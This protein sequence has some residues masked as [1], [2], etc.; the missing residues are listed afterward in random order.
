M[1]QYIVGG[2]ISFLAGFAIPQMSRFLMKFYP[3]SMHSYV[4]DLIRFSCQNRRKKHNVKIDNVVRNWLKKQLF[5]NKLGCGFLLAATYVFLKYY[6]NNFVGAGYPVGLLMGLIFLLGFA[7]NIDKRC[8]LIPDIITFPMFMVAFLISAYV[9]EM[10]LYFNLSISPL[11][12]IISAIVVYMLCFTIALIYYF[13][14]PFAFGGGD[15]K[16]LSALA[17]FTG[18]TGMGHILL[19]SFIFMYIYCKI[20]GVKFAPLAPFIFAAFLVWLALKI[21]LFAHFGITI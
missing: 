8:H 6:I 4:G 12:S 16:M 17:A 11:D 21:I 9:A 13:K 2:T 20:K 1:I 10:N 3:C 18:L 14:Q 5:F 19:L 7:A 15:V